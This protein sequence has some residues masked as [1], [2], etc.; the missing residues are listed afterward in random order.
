VHLQGEYYRNSKE[1]ILSKKKKFEGK[2][3]TDFKE[4]ASWLVA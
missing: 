3:K 4:G 1:E 2:I